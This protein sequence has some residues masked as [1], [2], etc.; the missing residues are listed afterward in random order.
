M[1]SHPNF[2]RAQAALD[3]ARHG[4]YAGHVTG[5]R[6]R[7]VTRC[8]SRKISTS[9]TFPIRGSGHIVQNCPLRS[10]CWADIPYLSAGL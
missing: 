4:D 2:D 6:L 9:L 5:R 1:T 7:S 10:V 8:W 3:A